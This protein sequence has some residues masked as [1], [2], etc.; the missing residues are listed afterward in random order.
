[1]W[2]MVIALAH[3]TP[4]TENFEASMT[5]KH[6]ASQADCIS[7]ARDRLSPLAAINMHGRYMCMYHGEPDR[8]MMHAPKW[9]F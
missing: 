2:F 8:E 5:Q 6:Y 4:L 1:M 3:V 9:A 7:D